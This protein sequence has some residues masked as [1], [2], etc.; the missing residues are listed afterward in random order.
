MTTEKKGWLAFAVILAML[1]ILTSVLQ[2]SSREKLHQLALHR[3]ASSHL[4]TLENLGQNI[5]E[6]FLDEDLLFVDLGMENL[7]HTEKD[8][9]QEMALRSLEIQETVGVFAF[10]RNGKLIELPTDSTRKRATPSRT[11]NLGERPYDFRFSEGQ[12]L[13][14]LYPVGEEA[15]IGFL[16]LLM[17]PVPILT[18]RDAVDEEIVQQGLWTFAIGAGLLFLIFRILLTRLLRSERELLNKSINLKEAN[19]RLSQ[20]CKTAGVGAVTAHLMHALKSPLMGLKNLELDTDEQLEAT[21]KN[22][23]STTRKIENLVTQTLNTL[24]EC[25]LNEESYSF[26]AKEVLNLAANKFNEEG[27][28][29]RVSVLESAASVEKIDNLKANLILP[30]LHN[31]IQNSIDSGPSVKVF[32]LAEQKNRSLILSV[33]DNGPGIAEEQKQNLFKPV[34]SQKESG[35]GIGLAISR[36][37]AERAGV[38]IQLVKSTDKGTTISVLISE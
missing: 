4:P 32:L 12:A 1:G 8:Y 17:D 26:E 36:E 30:I 20:A 11:E 18:E 3:E 5:E 14:I 25:D 33:R 29:S 37:L 15:E 28:E 31:L 38:T 16:E 19:L 22:L 35:S 13:S 23:R 34:H 6:E 10:D 21:E 2:F 24:R 7:V 9:L 27:P